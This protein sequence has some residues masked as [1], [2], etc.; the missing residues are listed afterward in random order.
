MLKMLLGTFGAEVSNG[1][2]L[3]SIAAIC[4]AFMDGIAG[5]LVTNAMSLALKKLQKTIIEKLTESAFE[6]AIPFR[7]RGVSDREPRSGH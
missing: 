1:L 6:K 5:F 2:S 7:K 4:S 3:P